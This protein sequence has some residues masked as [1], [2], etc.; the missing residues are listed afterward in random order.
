MNNTL[1]Q[2]ERVEACS[3]SAHNPGILIAD[4]M[5]PDPDFAQV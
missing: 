2:N 1:D 3:F 4:D 5:A